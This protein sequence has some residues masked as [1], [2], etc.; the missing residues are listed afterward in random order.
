M[1]QFDPVVA[2]SRD[3]LSQ[4]ARTFR[5]AAQFLSPHR[6]DDAALL[7]A[8]C[9]L[10]D[11]SVDMAPSPESALIAL[12]DLTYQLLGQQDPSD[13]IR[14]FLDMSARCQLHL[15]WALELI[16]GVRSDLNVV[17]FQT[18]VELLRYCYR[19]AGTVGLMM[20]AVLDVQDEL[21]YPYAVDLG[22][23]MQLTNICRDVAEDAQMG[24]VYLPNVR[25]LY[26]GTSSLELLNNQS[27]PHCVAH[28]VRDL[29]SLADAYYDSAEQGMRFIPTRSRVAIMVASRVYRA[30]G[31]Q[32]RRNG[33]NPLVGRTIVPWTEKS[34][35]VANALGR[36]TLPH[37]FGLT[38][39]VLHDQKLHVALR[40]LP[41][42][43]D[44]N[45]NTP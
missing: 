23:A 31:V 24:R 10:V 5:W 34:V 36:L 39:L 25:L 4:K 18:D 26:H 43:N 12:D 37:T 15:S 22:I 35:W 27:D 11:D 8:F 9:R 17:R 13:L 28:V 20:C 7:Y 30:I 40:G 33:C 29:L 1:T 41:G 6:H 14:A 3:V 45:T 32:L 2:Q 42:T 16:E 19:V 38:P 44:H 21:A